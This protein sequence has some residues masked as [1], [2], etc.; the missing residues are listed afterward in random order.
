MLRGQIWQMGGEHVWNSGWLPH[1]AAWL[2]EP[3]LWRVGKLSK[4][5]TQRRIVPQS[6]IKMWEWQCTA[7]TLSVCWMM[8]DSNTFILFSNPK[9]QWTTWRTPGF[10][11]S[12]LKQSCVV[13]LRIQSWSGLNLTI[14]VGWIWLE[15]RT[16]HLHWIRIQHQNQ[17]GHHDRNYKT[18][19]C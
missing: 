14:L 11:Y 10:K 16:T 6:K 7:T 3:D 19:R 1:L 5:Q 15:T 17:W 12:N 8:M 2:C 9:T 4:R 13:E 18:N